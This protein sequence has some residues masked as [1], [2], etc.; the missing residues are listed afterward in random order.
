L[1]K[2]FTAHKEYLDYLLAKDV[3]VI[4]LHLK[5]SSPARKLEK[6]EQ[7]KILTEF[8]RVG[9]SAKPLRWLRGYVLRWDEKS[10]LFD[11][12][13]SLYADITLFFEYGAQFQDLDIVESIRGYLN[14]FV[15]RINGES[16]STE[17][18]DPTKTKKEKK[19]LLGESIKIVQSFESVKLSN[20]FVELSDVPLKIEAD[21]NAIM[22]AF[23]KVY[24]PYIYY[25]DLFSPL[26]EGGRKIKRLTTGRKPETETKLAKQKDDPQETDWKEIAT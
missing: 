10:F 23:T 7:S 2:R 3:L 8:F 12:D 17:P 18:N 6:Q 11:N 13:K 5:F 1:E 20:S 16:K 9:R 14:D 21:D 15:D 26:E 24:L 19:H 4:R 22:Q 25:L